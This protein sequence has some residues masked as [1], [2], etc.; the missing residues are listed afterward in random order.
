MTVPCPGCGGL[1]EHRGIGCGPSG[2]KVM[3]IPCSDCKGVG[4]M[5]AADAE[6]LLAGRERGRMLREDRIRR[7]LSLREESRRLGISPVQLSDMER[8]KP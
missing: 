2:C 6:A 3:S 4:E 1:K 7:G 5:A 8:G